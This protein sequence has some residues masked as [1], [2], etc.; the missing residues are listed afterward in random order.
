MR[1]LIDCRLVICLLHL[2]DL[3]KATSSHIVVCPVFISHL[4]SSLSSP[5]LSPLLKPCIPVRADDAVV[6]TCAVDEPHGV[7]SICSRVVPEALCK[8]N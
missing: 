5:I 6:Q 8:D 3:A 1:Q 7:L 2:N 4:S